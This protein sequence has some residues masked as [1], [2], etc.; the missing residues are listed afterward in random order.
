MRVLTTLD[1]QGMTNS[2]PSSGEDGWLLKAKNKTRAVQDLT[3]TA[4]SCLDH[5][6]PVYKNITLRHS[7][8]T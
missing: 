3:K 6:Q 2:D 8:M 5:F 1:Q 4:L 7:C